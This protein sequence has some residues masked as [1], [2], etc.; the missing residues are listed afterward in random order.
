MEKSIVLDL[1]QMLELI[2]AKNKAFYGNAKHHKNTSKIW[3]DFKNL[4]SYNAKPA[5]KELLRIVESS[6]F[7][8]ENII[9]ESGDFVALKVFKG[10]GF[11][12]SY[13]VPY[14]TQDELKSAD[15]IKAHLENVATSGSVNALS[16]PY[17]LYDFIKSLELKNTQGREIDLLS[18]NEG[19]DWRKNMEQ[20]AFSDSQIKVI[21]A[22]EKG[23]WR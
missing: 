13:Y 5:L 3:V 9:V 18:W 12:T 23:A 14:Y 8:R 6:G 10:A 19:Q 4:D 17:Y 15:T 7:G 22:G 20:K 11:Y 1:A 21:L 2:V 16:F